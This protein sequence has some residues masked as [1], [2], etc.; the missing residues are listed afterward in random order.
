MK[1]P[2]PCSTHDVWLDS[3]KALYRLIIRELTGS[4]YIAG[5][6]AI[7]LWGALNLFSYLEILI[8]RALALY[9]IRRSMRGVLYRPAFLLSRLRTMLMQSEQSEQSE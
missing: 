6:L 3:L 7:L 4:T 5:L 1:A 9:Q 8:L 2:I